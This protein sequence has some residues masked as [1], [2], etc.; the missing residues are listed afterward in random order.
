MTMATK[1]HKAAWVRRPASAARDARLARAAVKVADAAADADEAEPVA[2]DERG[3]R[4]DPPKKK[5]GF[6]SRI[7]GGGDDKKGEKKEDKKDEKK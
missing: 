3:E 5:R 4:Q 2:I 6:W 1:G 7:F